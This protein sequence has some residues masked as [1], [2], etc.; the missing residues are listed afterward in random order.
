[1]LIDAYSLSNISRSS[2]SSVIST[3]NA[4]KNLTKQ[5]ENP[6]KHKLK[7]LSQTFEFKSEDKLLHR[8]SK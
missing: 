6:P 2:S 5:Q 4:S 1:M 8:M 7:P 3:S